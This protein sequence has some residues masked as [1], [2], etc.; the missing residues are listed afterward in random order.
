LERGVATHYHDVAG[1]EIEVPVDTLRHVLDV[2]GPPPPPDAPPPVYVLREGQE[3]WHHDLDRR[4]VVHLA[5]GGTR[6]LPDD[7]P[8]ALPHGR[9]LLELPDREVPLLVAPRTAHPPPDRREW[10]LA[11]QLYAVRSASGWG[12]GDLG[13]L[14]RLPEAAGWPGFVLVSPLH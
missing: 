6:P 12:I 3:P 4:A 2:L 13:D 1:R 8:G 9:H 11:V 7:L 10:G 5:D 14:A